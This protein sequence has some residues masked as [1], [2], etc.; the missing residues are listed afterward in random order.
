MFF[1]K[2]MNKMRKYRLVSIVGLAMFAALAFFGLS[3]TAAFAKTTSAT[4]TTTQVSTL[5]YTTS[6]ACPPNLGPAVR[7]MSP[8]TIRQLQ[9]FLSRQGFRVPVTG[10]FDPATLNAVK[11]F[12]VRHHF[13]PNGNVNPTLWRLLGQRC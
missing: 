3:S 2:E 4:T 8:A 6:N 9:T 12:Q 11:Q 10:R 13:S 1:R 5:D 7:G